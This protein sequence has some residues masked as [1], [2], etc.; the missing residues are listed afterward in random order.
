M[1]QS[2]ESLSDSALPSGNSALYEEFKRL[3]LQ[4]TGFMNTLK[5]QIAEEIA[6]A[7]GGERQASTNFDGIER[8]H[9]LRYRF[10]LETLESLK[11]LWIL[12][13]A[14]GCGYGSEMLARIAPTTGV[15]IDPRTVDFAEKH[16]RRG[17]V[18]YRVADVTALEPFDPAPDAIVSFETLEHVPE[19]TPMLA[20]FHGALS[21]SGTLLISTPNQSIRPFDPSDTPFHCRHY[22]RTELV[23]VLE[24]TGFR[25]DR[26]A[27]QFRDGTIHDA[28]TVAEEGDVIIAWATKR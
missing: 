16:F 9:K 20:A 21:S 8:R 6:V 19:A 13:A 2:T 27:F 11:P 12:D 15:D 10:A 7:N 22:T 1:N 28:E 25:V 3:L 17:P 4:D 18:S 5:W 24:E 26:T 14:C 23:Q